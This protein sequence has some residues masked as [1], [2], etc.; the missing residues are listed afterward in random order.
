MELTEPLPITFDPLLKPAEAAE[1]L[2]VSEA[3]LNKW[4]TKQR[5]YS[6]VQDRIHSQV[7]CL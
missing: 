7:P 6:C 4:R 2:S 1:Y 5:S 3:T